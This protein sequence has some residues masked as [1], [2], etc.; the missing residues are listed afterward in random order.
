MIKALFSLSI[1]FFV[2][3]MLVPFVVS[4]LKKEKA[5]QVILHYVEKHK[6]KEGTPTMGGIAFILSICIGSLFCFE[7]NFMLAG[8]TLIVTVGYGIIGFLDDFIKVK[9]KRNL[10]LR[11]YQKFLS[12]LFIAVSIGVFAFVSDFGLSQIYLPF[13]QKT[14]DF[15][16]VIIPFVAFVYLACTN[17]VNLTDGLDGLAASTTFSY[18]IPTAMIV[19][20]ITNFLVFNGASY[21][22]TNE[23]T[24]LLIVCGSTVGAMLGFLLFN[25]FPAKIFMGDTGS[26]ALGGLIAS[27]GIFT[28]T[29]LFLPIIGIMFVMSTV[30]VMIQVAY[31][32][33]TH[34][35]VFRMAPLHHHFEQKGVH[36]VKIVGWYSV[37]TAIIGVICVVG[38]YFVWS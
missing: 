37:I 27:I 25:G 11:A 9:F 17:S 2:T 6:S 35:R 26:L 1:T 24:N 5:K 8:L 16:W 13:S 14:I 10:G 15:G 18:M 29:V 22:V 19:I 34:K 7:G 28:K 31:Y 36:E 3:I 33:L 38:E 32:K 30:S 12:Q 4:L 21:P 23:Q 20:F